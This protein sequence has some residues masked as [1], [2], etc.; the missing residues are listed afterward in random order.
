MR[1]AINVSKAGRPA[2]LFVY[3]HFEKAARAQARGLGVADL[4]IYVFPQYKPGEA[5]SPEEANK[6]VKAAEDFP[7]LLLNT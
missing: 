5:L 2:V 7:K 6:A 3:N 1:D 4:K